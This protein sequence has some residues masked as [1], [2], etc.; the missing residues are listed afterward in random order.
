MKYDDDNFVCA[1][2]NL[3]GTSNVFINAIKILNLFERI[4]EEIE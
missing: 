4:R 1:M 2:M 3:P